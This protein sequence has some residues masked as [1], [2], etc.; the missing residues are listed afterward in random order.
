[1]QS[2][3]PNQNPT[4]SIPAE[5]GMWIFILMDLSIFALYFWVFAWGKNAHPEL[6]AEGQAN[7]NQIFAGLN[8]IALLTSSYFMATAVEAARKKD[9][10]RFTVNI[11]FTMSCGIIFL[12]IK[13]FEYEEKLSNGFGIVTNEFFRNYFSFTG[14]HLLHVIFGLGFLFYLLFG[15]KT[16]DECENKIVQIEGIGLYWHMVDLLWVVL[17]SL[18]YLAP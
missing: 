4:K 17:F 1:M 8:T 11:K 9:V 18:I 10:E 3:T 13:I 6:Y 15:I 5:L 14:F 7:L 2:E 16:K 12:I